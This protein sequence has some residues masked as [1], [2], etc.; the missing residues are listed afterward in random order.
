MIQMFA[1]IQ[2]LGSVLSTMNLIDTY[3]ERIKNFLC[4]LFSVFVKLYHEN[5]TYIMKHPVL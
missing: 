2:Q 3:I 4:Y 5:V 1:N